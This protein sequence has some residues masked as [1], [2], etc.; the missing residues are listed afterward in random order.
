MLR[1]ITMGTCV[2][3]QGTFVKSLPDGRVLV[4]VGKQVFSGKPVAK[5]A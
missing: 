2:S 1:T 4:R 5:A 3:V